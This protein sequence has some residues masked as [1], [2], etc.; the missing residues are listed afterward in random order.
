MFTILMSETRTYILCPEIYF[1]FEIPNYK[2]PV[3]KVL[4]P[5]SNFFSVYF[6]SFVLALFKAL[7]SWSPFYDI[8][9]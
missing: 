6:L 7:L 4:Q 8:K 1:N 3:Q 9:Y 5:L 2:H